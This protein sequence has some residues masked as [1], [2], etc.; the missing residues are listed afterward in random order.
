MWDNFIGRQVR[1]A[2]RNLLLTNLALLGVL[3][4]VTLLGGR[5]LVNF[6]LGPYP[7]NDSVLAKLKANE[8]PF[9]YYVAVKG[10]SFPE[11]FSQEIS[12]KVD[13]RTRQVK[14]ESHVADFAL[15]VVGR[16]LLIVK[17]PGKHNPTQ[18]EFTGALVPIPGK[19]QADLTSEAKKANADFE[20]MVYPYMLD[21]TGFRG[22]GYVGLIIGLPLYALAWWN[23]IK[24]FRRMGR[25]ERH[26][27]VQWL[28]H[29]GTPSEV[30]QQI[31][32]QIKDERNVVRG[33]GVTMTSTWFFW[34]TAYGLHTNHV[35]DLIWIYKKVTKHS[36][37]FIPT[38]TTTAA[39]IHTRFGRELEI[40]AG[41]WT[42]P[43]LQQVVERAP[44]V[45]V[46]YSDDLAAIWSKETLSMIAEVDQRR[47]QILGQY[48][49]SGG[50]TAPEN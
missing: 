22:P 24:A 21:T 15:V 47:E 28:N 38:G 34:S 35:F 9:E 50:D 32:A 11:A 13:K 20:E 30:A 36:Y 43:L 17:V 18:G 25:Y 33:S 14:S 39:A 2:N 42:E 40:K 4:A 49:Q 7:A 31:E 12:Q 23:I 6:L 46:G 8:E 16:R 26:P 3:F 37:N 5:Y 27:I 44:W 1:R 19:I 41:S 45:I 10:Q 29:Y 48:G